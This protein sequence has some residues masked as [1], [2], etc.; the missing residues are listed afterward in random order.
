M[1]KLRSAPVWMVMGIIVVLLLAVG[2]T[3]DSGP[4]TQGDRIDAITKRI[5]CP[6]C[7]G[8]SVYVSRASAAEAIRRQVA[9]DVAAGSMADDEIIASI[10]DTFKAQ[11]LLVPRATGFD[12]LV[13]VLPIVAL[14]CA[15]AGLW[16]AFRRW[17]VLNSGTASDDD[18]ALVERMLAEDP[19]VEDGI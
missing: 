5:A 2:S 10:A 12:S 18:V 11:V 6:T 7:D 3:R 4:R 16:S 17:K 15:V 8:E 13:W 14:V 19:V 1:T 9:R